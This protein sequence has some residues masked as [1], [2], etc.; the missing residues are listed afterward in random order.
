MLPLFQA[1]EGDRSIAKMMLEIAALNDG[2][3]ICQVVGK[4]QGQV[5]VDN[6]L[7]FEVFCGLL[8]LRVTANVGFLLKVD[9]K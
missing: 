9:K 1:V 7:I 5:P 3:K 6:L 8:P 2:H 4:A